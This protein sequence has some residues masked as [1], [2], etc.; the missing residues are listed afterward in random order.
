MGHEVQNVQ[1]QPAPKKSKVWLWVLI[2]IVIL[3]II[4]YF[5]VVFLKKN[6]KTTKTESV[7]NGEKIPIPQ[8]VLDNKFGWLGGGAEDTGDAISESGGAWV[9][10][11]PGAFVWDMMQKEKDSKI[12]FSLAD[13]EVQNYQKNNLGILATIWPFADWDQKNLA[14][15]ADCKVAS[16]DEFLPKNDK[17]G[18]GSYLPQYRCNPNDWT[19]YQKFV[20]A[21]VERYDGDGVDDMPGL[22][23][24]IKYWEVMNE[25]DLQYENNLPLS[26]TSSLNF[27]KQGPLDYGELLK[28]TYS[29]IKSADPEAKVLIAGAAGGSDQFL[30][31]YNLLFMRMADVPNYF[32]IGNVHCISNDQETYDFNV[33]VYKKMLASAGI[34]AKLIWVTEAEAMYG[35]TGEENYQN[36]K[37]ST[38]GAIAAGAQRIFFT[39]YNFDDFRTD[40]SKKTEA[41]SYPSAK[42]YKELIESFSK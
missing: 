18:R 22:K 2:I 3:G 9:R 30:G 37:K 13:Q 11:H 29:P 26:E 36:T 27:Y 41:G 8:K 40:M 28:K 42:K 32:D 14:N 19:A 38:E 5:G 25:P 39:R 12:D 33:T 35:Q 7:S 1:G 31:F 23:M 15:V 4:G 24:P 6:N 21:I 34:T 20:Q 17:K 10:P 16:N